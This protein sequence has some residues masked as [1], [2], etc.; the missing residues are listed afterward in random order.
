MLITRTVGSTPYSDVLGGAAQVLESNWREGR[1]ADSRTYGYTCPDLIKYP[2]QFFWDSC[3]HALTWSRIDP[4][5]AMQ[6]LRSLGAPQQESG[7]IGH[8]TFWQGPVRPS[9][10]LTYNLLHRRAFQTATIQPPLLGWVWAEVA[11]RSGDGRFAD[12][13][14]EVVRRLH[15]Y[16]DRERADA[17]G[18][19]GIL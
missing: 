2:D 12:E 19:L 5:R 8:T 14:R 4:R 6:E 3:F 13:G 1:T 9:R 15:E 7:M 10:A 17:D 18:L 16:L 11:E